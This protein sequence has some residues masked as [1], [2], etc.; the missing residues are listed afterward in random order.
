MI[1]KQRGYMMPI[2]FW[3]PAG[4]VCSAGTSNIPNLDSGQDS[5]TDAWVGARWS[6]DGGVYHYED[7]IAQN[8]FPGAA[9]GGTWQGD[10][11]TSE[12]DG[13][14]RKTFGDAPDDVTP[15]DG[16]WVQMSVGKVEIEMNS[17]GRSEEHFGIFIFELRRRS[18]QVII[19]TDAFNMTTE[20]IDEK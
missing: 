14:W 20:T 11:N 18:D 15:A 9:N 4:G 7:A 17:T 5:P 6:T 2:G 12:Y 8:Q 10:C 1:H 3:V 19:L 13:R 16:T